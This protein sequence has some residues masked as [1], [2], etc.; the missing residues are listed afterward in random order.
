MEIGIVIQL[1]C[2][3]VEVSAGTLEEMCNIYV[4]GGHQM[5]FSV[6]FD[7]MKRLYREEFGTELF[8]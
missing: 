8:I 5:S 6:A 7:R 4:W 2:M 3:A 1:Q